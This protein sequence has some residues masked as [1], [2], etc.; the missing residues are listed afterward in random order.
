MKNI[1]VG[2][3]MKF[4]NIFQCMC[5]RYAVK[6]DIRV[7]IRVLQVKEEPVLPVEEEEKVEKV[8][9]EESVLTKLVLPVAEK[10]P[11]LLQVDI[12]GN[13]DEISVVVYYDEATISN[14]LDDNNSSPY[15]EE[16]NEKMF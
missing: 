4:Y 2:N 3:I 11:I 14:D 5:S 10:E 16:M 9:E 6:E 1:I 12:P 13:D 7:D 8:E 15:Y